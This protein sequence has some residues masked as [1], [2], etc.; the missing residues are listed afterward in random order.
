MCEMEGNEGGGGPCY[1]EAT[2][3][4]YH[5]TFGQEGNYF[6]KKNSVKSQLE[7]IKLCSHA[8]KCETGI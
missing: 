8:S 4:K 5:H 2:Y 1:L 7:N 6:R 3:E